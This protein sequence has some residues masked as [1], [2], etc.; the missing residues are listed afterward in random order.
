MKRKNIFRTRKVVTE[1]LPLEDLMFMMISFI[2]IDVVITKMSCLS[3]RSIVL[4]QPLLRWSTGTQ[5]LCCHFPYLCGAQAQLF[6]A[7]LVADGVIR[8]EDIDVYTFGSPR[9]GDQTFA[10]NYDRVSQCSNSIWCLK[11]IDKPPN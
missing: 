5:S 9:V 7:N 8:A 4:L 2:A 10:Y 6:G 1:G 3:S 11:I